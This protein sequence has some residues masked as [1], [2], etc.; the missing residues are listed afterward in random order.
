MRDHWGVE[1]RLHECLDVT[2]SEDS[3]R[4][5]MDSG[6]QNL[7]V[8]RHMALNVMRKEEAKMSQRGKL[9]RLIAGSGVMQTD[10]AAA[11]VGGASK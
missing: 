8:L 3:A 7:A 6:P 4:N 2:M 10:G 1:N 11:K 9:K 5:R